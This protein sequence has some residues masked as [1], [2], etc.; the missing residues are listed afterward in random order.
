[1]AFTQLHRHLAVGT[2]FGEDALLLTEFRGQEGISRLFRFDLEM[3]S[4]NPSLDFKSIV[5]KN[6]TIRVNQPDHTDRFFNGIV[7]RFSQSGSDATFTSYHA[8]VVPWL[9]LLT[10]TADCKIFQKMTA[11]DIIQAVFSTYGLSNFRNSL[12]GTYPVLEYCVQYRETDFN[13]VCRLMEE[14]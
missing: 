1:M 10:R 14:Y 2:P 11:P 8:E 7:S 13:F 9:W 12:R 5:G 4:E 3:L 6:V